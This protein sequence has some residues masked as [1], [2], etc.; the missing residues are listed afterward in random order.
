MKEKLYITFQT[1]ILT[2][3]TPFRPLTDNPS[4]ASVR[5]PR[6]DM[7]IVDRFQMLTAMSQDPDTTSHIA[8]VVSLLVSCGGMLQN[9]TFDVRDMFEPHRTTIGQLVLHQ[10][11]L[12]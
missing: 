1:L 9:V 8:L 10:V 2:I 11:L 3:C 4:V 12:P 7:A 5:G 6:H